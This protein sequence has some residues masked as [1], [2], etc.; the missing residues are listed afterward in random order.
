MTFFM[1]SLLLLVSTRSMRI[2]AFGSYARSF[3]LIRLAKI[4]KHAAFSWSNFIY[5]AVMYR[6]RCHTL[7]QITNTV[8][9]QLQ[10][11]AVRIGS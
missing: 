7:V 1:L 8:A 10:F 11:S 3:H 6:F 5:I 4:L 9:F 2:T